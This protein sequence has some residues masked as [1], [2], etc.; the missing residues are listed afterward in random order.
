MGK[1]SEK[2]EKGEL[3]IKK[4]TSRV[5]K[6]S[7]LSRVSSISP[8]HIL[9]EKTKQTVLIGNEKYQGSSCSMN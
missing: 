3:P 6:T 1:K 4:I 2:Q 7:L 8:E 5:L 9:V